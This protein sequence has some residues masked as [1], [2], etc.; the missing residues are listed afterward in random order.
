MWYCIYK[1]RN[2]KPDI[3]RDQGFPAFVRTDY[4]S[5]SYGWTILTHSFFWPRFIFGWAI[6]FFGMIAGAIITI[7]H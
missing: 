5:W 1:Y 2:L 4:D 7:G 3:K 6:C